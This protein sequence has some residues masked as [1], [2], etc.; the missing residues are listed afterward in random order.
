M[1]LGT[2]APFSLLFSLYYNLPYLFHILRT[3]QNSKRISNNTKFLLTP[4]LKLKKES[5]FVL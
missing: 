5:W 2:I 4:L 3:V 1:D